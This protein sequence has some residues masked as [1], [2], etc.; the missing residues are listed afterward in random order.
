MP[1][2]SFIYAFNFQKYTISCIIPTLNI[3]N[4]ITT[5]RLKIENFMKLTGLKNH[6]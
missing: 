6:P 4:E 1:L 3:K 5:I 2:T